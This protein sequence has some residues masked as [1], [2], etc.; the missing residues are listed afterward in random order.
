MI[1]KG[2]SL[3]KKY[4]YVAIVLLVGLALLVMPTGKEEKTV[5]VTQNTDEEYIEKIEARLCDMLG[6]INGAGQVRL[7]LTPQYGSRT[8]YHSDLH[9]EQ[10]ENSTSEDRKT[11][12]LS[13]GSAYDKAAVSAV[14]YPQFQGALVVCQGADDPAVRL[15]IVNA[16]SALTGLGSDRITV[17]KM[18]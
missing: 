9:T 6:R 4:K 12:I 7:M 2:L 5:P 16:V 11:V 14:R 1:E 8:E 10:D 13:T 3:I 15:D 18:N 17:V